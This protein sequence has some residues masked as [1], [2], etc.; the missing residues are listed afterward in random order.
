MPRA[1][2]VVSIAVT[3]CS[4]YA[5][6]SSITSAWYTSTTATNTIS[7]TS[8]ATPHVAGV[9]ALY[10][11]Q[12]GYQSPATVHSAIISNS[13]SGK[14]TS[15]GT[16]SPNRLLYSLFATA[17]IPPTA[18]FTYSCS[19][20]T[21]SF[22]G[23]SS[24]DDSG[25]VSYE[26]SF[27]DGG[28]G[29]DVTIDHTYAAAGTYTVTLTVTDTAIPGQTGSQSQSVTVSDGGPPCTS[30]EHYSGFVSG[31]GA[32]SYQPNGTY[33]FSGAGAHRGWLR[34]PS[35]TDL[36]LYLYK[37]NGFFWSLVARSEGPTSEE[38]ITY[39]GTSGYYRWRIYSYFGSGSYDFWLIRP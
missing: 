17:D 12:H 20:L 31:T 7:G 39:T 35:G 38:Q 1:I 28:S 4:R 2:A 13:T 33:Y 34:G 29:S 11:H 23:S 36:D 26:W 24:F 3:L 22:D 15:P 21:C 8:M 5:P 6:G 10:L 25:I 19:G 18:S 32:S 37:W 9:V 16:G 14:V 30:C 27:G